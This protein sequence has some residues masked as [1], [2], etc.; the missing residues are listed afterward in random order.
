MSEQSSA[1]LIIY[2]GLL[3]IILIGCLSASALTYLLWL[4]DL[5]GIKTNAITLSN[6]CNVSYFN[7][8]YNSISNS[9]S[10]IY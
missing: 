7:L 6:V 5:A 2:L 10:F 8:K 9:N 1:N 4:Y 3:F